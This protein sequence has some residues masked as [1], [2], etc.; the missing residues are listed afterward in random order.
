MTDTETLRKTVKEGLDYIKTQKDIRDAEVFVSWYDNIT[1]RINYTSDIPCNGVQEPKNILGYG[2]GIFASFNTPDGLKTGYGSETSDF[3]VNGIKSAL[4]KARINSVFDLDFRSLPG[5][6]GDEIKT[7]TED[8]SFEKEIDDE[9]I[10]SLGWKAIQS[11]VLEFDRN[12]HSESLVVGGD[13]NILFE[14]M[15]VGN[16]NGLLVSD[17]SSVISSS[18]TAMIENRDAKGTGWNISTRLRDFN[19]ELAGIM[20]AKS[21]ISSIGGTRINTG[22]YKVIFG[23]QA[24]AMLFSEMIISALSLNSIDSGNSPFVNRYGEMVANK[25]LNIYD[26]GA[27]PGGVASKEFT[28]EGVPAGRTDLIRQGRLV[29]FLANHYYAQKLGTNAVGFSPRNGFKFGRGGGRDY[30]RKNSIYATNLIIEGSHETDTNGLLSRVKN[31]I[32][33]GR[34]WYLYPVYGLAKADFTGTITGDSYIIKDGKIVSALKPNTVRIT[35]NFVK[36]LRD[37]VAVSKNKKPT[38]LWDTE[39]VIYAPEI[40][41]KGIRLESIAE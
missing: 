24:V 18:I 5:P 34:L 31:G 4:G 36:L 8:R 3:T 14:K 25:N 11:A 37:V 23:P 21:T 19:P 35:D 27:M 28:C 33:I 40:A 26:Y 41:V 1:V 30:R 17:Q 16:T 2:I 29:G 12:R 39:E 15:S 13:I 7:V 9:Q 22:K 10:I 6:S 20:A 32:Y 38:Q